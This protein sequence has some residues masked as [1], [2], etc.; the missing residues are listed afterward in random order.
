MSDRNAKSEYLVLSRGQWDK[1]LSKEQIQT[2]I[3]SFYIW[4]EGMIDEGKMK[5]G[6]RLA[7]GGKTVGA[8][9][10]IVDGPFGES[11]EVIGGYWFITAENLEEAAEYMS[12]NPCIQCGLFFELRPLELERASAYAETNETPGER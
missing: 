7:V 4:I 9:G 1:S 12:G 2:A 6:Q 11:K 8:K 10:V 3:D 5:P